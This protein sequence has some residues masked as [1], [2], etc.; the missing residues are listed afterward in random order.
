MYSS[1]ADEKEDFEELVLPTAK[2]HNVF[3]RKWCVPS[4]FEVWDNP[5]RINS[6]STCQPQL[7]VFPTGCLAE[8]AQ[9]V[10]LSHEDIIFLPAE[11]P[12]VHINK[13]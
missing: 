5:H 1:L 6:F 4:S 3:V 11:S 10:P 13:M 9:G 12:Y 8:T 7:Q 2:T